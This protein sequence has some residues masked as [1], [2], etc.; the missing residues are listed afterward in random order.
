MT[1]FYHKNRHHKYYP[2]HK[3]LQIN[4]HIVWNKVYYCQLQEMRIIG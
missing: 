2:V 1:T 4:I 3:N